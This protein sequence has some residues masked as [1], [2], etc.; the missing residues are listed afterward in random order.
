MEAA[1]N[2]L[3]YLNW[4]IYSFPCHY[5]LHYF[6]AGHKLWL[7]SCSQNAAVSR[8]LLEGSYI[9][10]PCTMRMPVR[11]IIVLATKQKQT[12]AQGFV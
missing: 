2:A 11:V 8:Y 6:V 9:M 7:S 1:L 12:T 3:H 10:S 4:N 5:T